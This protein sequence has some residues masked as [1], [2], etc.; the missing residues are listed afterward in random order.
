MLDEYWPSVTGDGQQLI[1]TRE[2]KRAAGY[3]R[4]RQEDFYISRWA[5]DGYWGTGTKCRS[6]AEHCRQRRGTVNFV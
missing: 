1:F 2:V 4:D 3:G 6:P 5:G